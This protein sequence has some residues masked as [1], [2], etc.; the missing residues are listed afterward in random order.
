ML[1]CDVLAELLS[2]T[3]VW[4]HVG[5]RDRVL[6]KPS[7]DKKRVESVRDG[8]RNEDYSPDA[9]GARSLELLCES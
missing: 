4:L 2:L 6:L 1:S 9:G 7:Q 8:D 3:L 5:I